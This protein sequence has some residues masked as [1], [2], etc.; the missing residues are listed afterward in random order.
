MSFVARTTI[1]V[2]A[3]TFC[4]VEV[5][6]FMSALVGSWITAVPDPEPN[7]SEPIGDV[8]SKIEPFLE[9]MRAAFG[10]QYLTNLHKLIDATP[11]GR[12]RLAAIRERMQRIRGEMAARQTKA[13]QQS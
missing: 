13:P 12:E 8:F 6:L 7:A 10:P 5:A 11:G 4:F 9:E 3:L 2:V 1:P